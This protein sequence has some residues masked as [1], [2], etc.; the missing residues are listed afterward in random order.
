MKKLLFNLLLATA[1]VSYAQPVEQRYVFALKNEGIHIS[2]IQARSTISVLQKR[3][4][5]NGYQAMVS[6]DKAKAVFVVKSGEVIEAKFINDWLLKPGKVFFYETYDAAMLNEVWFSEADGKKQADKKIRFAQL[7]NMPASYETGNYRMSRSELGIVR[8]ADTTEFNKIKKDLRNFI[9]TDCIFAYEHQEDPVKDSV[10]KVYAI[11]NNAWA[12]PAFSMLASA[13]AG[14]DE[15]MR[16]AIKLV[17]NEAGTK[18]FGK[19]TGKNINR[20]LAI[21][22]DGTVYSAP[23]V[24][25]KIDGGKV[26]ITGNFTEE[27]ARQIANMLSGGYLQLDL[28]LTR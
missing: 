5:N 1:A 14:L 3:L 2:E 21:V 15:R 9:P 13:K 23:M 4:Q 16:P 28:V 25:S 19:I 20:A 26:E 12:M 17:F 22:V 6:Y 8:I 24:V 18:R 10:L 11:I 7:L 27:E